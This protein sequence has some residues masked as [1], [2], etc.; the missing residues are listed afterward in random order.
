MVAVMSSLGFDRFSVAGHDRGGY[1][2][3][4]LA[5]DHPERIERLAVLDI[6]PA[7][8]A[9]KRANDRFMLSWWHWAFLAQ[10]APLAETWIGRDP[11]W[12][13]LRNK[14]R[15]EVSH[16]D[17]LADYLRCYNNPDT[18]HA[19]CEDYRANATIDR[20]EEE[21]DYAAG[22]RITCPTLV[23]WG[24]E[25]DLEDLY[26]DPLAVWRAWAPDVRGRGLDSG[27]FLAEEAP[28]AVSRELLSFFSD[29]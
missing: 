11:E 12:Y 2:S 23:L 8:E 5:L 17:A 27:H 16:P 26:G 13:F 3:Y 14:R 21:A 24:R 29:R 1:C 9:W 20:A 15:Q 7:S 4:R 28:D 25:D 10:P 19:I 18:I 22:K 6:V